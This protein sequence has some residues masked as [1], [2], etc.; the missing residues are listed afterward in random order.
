MGDNAHIKPLEASKFFADGKTARPL[1]PGTVPR[2]RSRRRRPALCG[3]AAT[4]DGSDCVSKAAD[5]SR[6]RARATAIQHLLHRLPR[7]HRQ[8]RRHDRSAR[9]S[10]SAFLLSRPSCATHRRDIFTTSSR[11][12]TARCTATAIASSKTTAGKSSPTFA[13]CNSVTRK[14]TAWRKH[15]QR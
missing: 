13:P 4:G 5:Q 8:G 10:T 15:R 12:A 9:L 11:T 2:G 3:H 6:H 7:R 14:T 1:V